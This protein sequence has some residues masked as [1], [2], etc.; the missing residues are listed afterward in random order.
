M[1]TW[2]ESKNCHQMECRC[3]HKTFVS[4]VG[5]RYNRTLKSHEK[6]K[7]KKDKKKNRR[8]NQRRKK[9]KKRR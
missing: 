8:R 3:G 6:R 1:M 5:D 7:K 9:A 4:I 2:I